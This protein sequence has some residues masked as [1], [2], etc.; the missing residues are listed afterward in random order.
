MSR[1]PRPFFSKDP[2]WF[3][4]VPRQQT[5]E[6]PKDRGAPAATP[7]TTFGSIIGLCLKGA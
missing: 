2:G 6:P 1:R 4:N 7:G 3:A 5:P